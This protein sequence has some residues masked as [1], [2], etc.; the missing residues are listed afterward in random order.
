M[1]EILNNIFKQLNELSNRLDKIE[2]ALREHKFLNPEEDP[3]LPE[4]I[5]I[6]QGYDRA[7]ASLLQR[8]L[9]IG[10]ARAARILDQLEEK[11]VVSE[12]EG[13]LPRVVLNKKKSKLR[14]N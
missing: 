5:K 9:K 6:V 4:A 3:L 8:R 10:Y 13:S 7:S 1:E 14:N 11:G 2:S 12:D